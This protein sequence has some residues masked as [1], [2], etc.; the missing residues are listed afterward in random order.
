MR[1]R[2]QISENEDLTFL[3][4]LLE[5]LFMPVIVNANP[6]DLS[7]KACTKKCAKPS[8]ACLERSS[9]NLTIGL[10][11]N[12][13]D[14]ALEATERQFTALLNS[15]SPDITIRLLLYSLP[16]IPRNEASAD[17]I[18]DLYSSTETLFDIRLD[19]L[20]VTGRE[21]LTPNLRDEPYWESF[22]N[23]LEWAR[24]NTHSTI[25]SCLAAHAA[26]LYQDDI[27]R[28]KSEHKHFGI[29]DCECV[30]KHPLT[31]EIPSRFKLP[32]SRWNGLPE[33]ELMDHGYKVLSRT[34]D[35]G[36]DIFA[37][38]YKSLFVFFQGH[39]EY[40]SNTLRLEYQRDIGR[41]LRG[42]MTTYP[43]LPHGYF[44]ADSQ[45]RLAELQ[46]KENQGVS[47]G[48][49]AEV[50]ET[51]ERATPKFAWNA[52]AA[53]IYKNWIDYIC[54]QKL[55][56]L[57][58]ENARRENVT[59]GPVESYGNNVGLPVELERIQ[60][61]LAT[62]NRNLLIGSNSNCCANENVVG[63]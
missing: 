42:E 58:A 39:P 44:D 47:Q 37:K 25:W 16:G 57:Q 46:Q 13:P 41:F 52:T 24:N 7:W 49:P 56:D 50:F 3:N 63:L 14:S 55:G 28:I 51:L 20:I 61:D 11:N 18:C 32:H 29:F 19:G 1:W 40:E 23:I 62:L 2:R 8:A 34:E 4:S 21:P 60:S 38:Q 30:M 45:T 35:A 59:T 33:N 15:A 54:T 22:T 27:Q 9:K 48:L 12:M 5:E 17:R 53:R 6:S 43:R 10:I 26:V 31:A 36:V